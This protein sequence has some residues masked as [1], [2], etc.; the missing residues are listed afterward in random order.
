MTDPDTIPPC[1]ISS[2][3]NSLSHRPPSL[4]SPVSPRPSL[5]PPFIDKPLPFKTIRHPRSRSPSCLRPVAHY[6]DVLCL[7][8]YGS[9]RI[10][11]RAVRLGIP[12]AAKRH[13]FGGI[14]LTLDPT[15]SPLASLSL[16]LAFSSSPVARWCW[17]CFNYLSSIAHMSVVI[18]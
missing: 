3:F 11:M 16:S 5:V 7:G 12:L 6:D 18:Y 10:Y 17:M 14:L 2:P 8:V 9:G 1:Q 15:R 13:G 4:A